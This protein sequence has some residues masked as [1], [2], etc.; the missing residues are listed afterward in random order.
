MLLSV[1][2]IPRVRLSPFARATAALALAAAA[3]APL[4]AADSATLAMVR[5]YPLF[6]DQVRELARRHDHLGWYPEKGFALVEA[7]AAE[8]AQLEREGYR[9]EIDE[10]RTGWLRLALEAQ[11]GEATTTIPGFPCYRTVEETF[12]T[13]AGLV[14]TYPTLATWS[15]IGDSWKKAQ[16]AAQ[17]Y[18]MRV[19]RLTNSAIPG[20]KPALLVTA[21]IHAREYTTAE[22]ATR[23]AE[24]LLA[25]YGND[26][27]ATW[28][29][30]HHEVHLVLHTNPDGRKVAETGSSWRKNL[31]N[32][33][34]CASTYGVDLNRNFDF[35]WACCG[36][37]SGDACDETYHG[38]AAGSEPETQTV[39]SYMLGL[40]QDWRGPA[41][42]DPASLDTIGVYVDLH[43]YQ[44]AILSVFGFQDPPNP[45]NGPELL[46]LGRKWGYLS[47][48]PAQLGSL[49]P[50]DGST[51]DYL[52]GVL[53]IPAYTWEMGTAFF[54]SCASFEAG[55]LPASHAMLRYAARAARAPYR[56]S[57]GPD[58]VEAAF[59]DPVAAAGDLL[60]VAARADDTRY[61]TATGGPT[62]GQA[63]AAA[64]LYV[65]TPPWSAGAA[66]V[67][68]APGDGTFNATSEAIV[69]SIDTTALGVGRHFAYLRARDAGNNWGPVTA[70]FFWVFAPGTVP[71][72]EG[73]VH[74][75]S[76]GAP[77]AASITTGSFATSSD[78]G[79]GAYGLDL[80]PGTYDLTA[81]R[82]GFGSA[83][84]SG[85]TLASGPPVQR[86]FTLFPAPFADDVESGTGGWT[87]QSPWAQ[88]TANAHS[89][90]HSWTDSPS[91]SYGNNV[92]TSLTSP[93]VDLSGRTGVEIAF[94]HRYAL[95]SSW[96]FG[97]VEISTNGGSTWTEKARYTGTQS[98][99][100]AVRLSVPELAGAAQARVRF[101]LTSDSS[102]VFDG[103]YVDDIEISAAAP[104]LPFGDGFEA[105][106]LGRWN[107]SYAAP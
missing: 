66:P 35:E 73:T 86:D 5:A 20:P 16:N 49:Y 67:A 23:F 10:E 93:I 33:D 102:Q 71:H 22:A 81:T 8:R 30:D 104:G 4:P 101:R 25:Q 46:R 75:G 27:E 90:T 54:E 59:P 65:D 15:D 17:G 53:G 32:A 19:L 79:T 91:G 88:T 96:D 37:S 77:L 24:W 1:F 26:P 70:L 68:M 14:A 29:L 105:G 40:F 61:G 80:P 43:S 48:Y 100:G 62:E 39:Q 94:W 45:P 57:A 92:N 84:A 72:V 64:E 51:K 95:E 60:A 6:P 76:N 41:I 21:A 56:L 83:S 12:A 58:V 34:G 74:N 52:Y 7:D 9:L 89:P 98:T 103:W 97:L 11:R 3:A 42:T 87:A 18:D 78:A 36:G 31:N 47:G 99:W 44:P 13:A 38:A 63:I 69:G 55:V 2:V 82:F 85:V 50:V 106:T 28:L 107:G